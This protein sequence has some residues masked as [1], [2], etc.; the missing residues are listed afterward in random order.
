VPGAGVVVNADLQIEITMN[1]I[2]API[3]IEIHD[4]PRAAL[5]PL[6]EEADDSGEEIDSYIDRGRVLL[7]IAGDEVVGHLQLTETASPAELEIKSTAVLESHRRRGIGG[8]MIASALALAREES[9]QLVLVATAT[10]DIDN[11][12]FYQRHG[13]RMQSIERDAFTAANGYPP[14]TTVDG[15]PLRDR[16]WLDQVL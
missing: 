9:R 7:A 13:F 16:I 8:R 11:L 10:A 2:P 14:G 4:G 3:R 5:R 12:R 6:F 1:E 15:I